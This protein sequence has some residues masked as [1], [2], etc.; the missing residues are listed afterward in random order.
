LEVLKGQAEHLGGALEDIRK[1]I[2]KLET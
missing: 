1:R 2:E